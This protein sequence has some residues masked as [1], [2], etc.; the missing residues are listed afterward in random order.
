MSE[1]VYLDETIKAKIRGSILGLAVG[2]ALGAPLEFMEP[3]TFEPLDDMEGGAWG[4]RL[5]AGDWTD[6]TSLAL[7]LG[8]SLLESKGFD[9]RDQIQRYVRWYKKGYMSSVG[10]CFDIGG[11]TANALDRFVNDKTKCPWAGSTSKR[12]GG[13][14]SLMRLAPVPL[15]YHADD[16]QAVRL[17]GDS[18]Y[19]TH[20]A[21]TAVDSCR[22]YG[23]LIAKALGGESKEAL[24]DPSLATSGPFEND[25]L[26]EEVLEIALGSYKEKDPPEVKAGGYVIRTLE[27]A[28]WAFHRTETFEEG[29]LK[30]INLGDDADTVGAIFGQLAGAYYGFEAI[31]RKWRDQVT[32]F[33]LLIRLADGLCDLSCSTIELK[34]VEY[35]GRPVQP[36]VTP[37]SPRRIE[38]P[39]KCWWIEEDKVLGGP[40]PGEKDGETARARLQRLLDFG[41]RVFVDLME[42]GE[43]HWRTGD[44][45]LPYESTLL[46]LAAERDI[47]VERQQFFIEDVSV[48]KSAKHMDFVLHSIRQAVDQSRLAYVHCLGGHG[49]TGTVAGCWLL[50]RGLAGDDVHTLDL[51]AQAREHD[52]F[53]SEHPSPETGKQR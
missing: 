38:L 30:A 9:L 40:F 12:R 1:T 34:E 13:N 16:D 47:Q 11:A 33:D 7:C 44:L 32:E 36:E 2:D 25:P 39:P 31:P 29:V 22:F 21:L 41:V 24:L 52:K 15:L 4:G 35:P 26:E 27:A 18:S 48:P 28:L 14:G 8:Y 49:R 19:T 17:S 10:E 42:D 5:E 43:S 37:S 53:L 23:L 45:F 6:D 20:G 46:D 51:I 50:E 3:S